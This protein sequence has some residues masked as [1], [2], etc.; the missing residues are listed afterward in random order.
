MDSA[1]TDCHGFPKNF[2]KLVSKP[3]KPPVNIPGQCKRDTDS[4]K[5]G[6]NINTLQI[7]ENPEFGKIRTVYLNDEPWLVGKDVA[8]A[9]GYAKPENAVAAHVD[10]EDKTTTL[11]QGT[12]SN[13]KSNAVVINESGLYSLVLSSKLPGAKRFR[14]WITS[15]VIPTLRKF[16]AYMTPET[17][18]QLISSP[19]FGIRLLTALKEER[20][21]SAALEQQAALD[22][23]YV[24][25]A[26]TVTES[27]GAVTVG[28]F[29]KLVYDR[30]G[31]KMG[32]NQMFKW[33]RLNGFLTQDNTPYQK[34]LDL[35]WFEVCE[36]VKYGKSYIVTLITGLGQQKL[37]ER[38]SAA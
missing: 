27:E 7:F 38:L 14:R 15:E 22:A 30:S 1:V 35:G 6:R 23:P 9:L 3:T 2:S 19:D 13:Y 29:A 17:L 28:K 33:L 4:K 34:Y 16:G 8:T 10:G 11:I 26:K 21:K 24:A 36:V 32:R 25:F 37:Y 31:I 5:G 12:G 20:E 18:E